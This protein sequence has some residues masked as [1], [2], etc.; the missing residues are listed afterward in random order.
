[1]SLV[2]QAGQKQLPQFQYMDAETCQWIAANNP[3]FSL[4]GKVNISN[5]ILSL[6]V[7]NVDPAWFLEPKITNSLHGVR[8]LRRCA[9]FSPYLSQYL[10]LDYRVA[11]NLTIAALL[12]DIRRVNDQDDKVHGQRAAQW[13]RD[14]AIVI[15]EYMNIKLVPVDIEAISTAIELHETPYDLFTESQK[16]L[17]QKNI[18]ITDALKTLDALDRYRLPKLKWWID[19]SHLKIVPPEWLKQVAF[20][21]VLSSEKSC[22]RDQDNHQLSFESLKDGFNI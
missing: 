11:R 1:M 19:D 22:L 9:I 16:L 4:S 13:V 5:R 2:D 18:I 14:N 17:Y 6:S 15:E 21:L 12:H 8:H 20:D 3:Q 7:L 10:E